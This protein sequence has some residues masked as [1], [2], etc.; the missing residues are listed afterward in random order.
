[1][2]TWPQMLDEVLRPFA[3]KSIAK[4]LNSL[5]NITKLERLDLLH[6]EL[7]CKTFQ[8]NHF[9][10]SLAQFMCYALCSKT[11]EEQVH[12][13]GNCVHELGCILDILP[14]IPEAFHLYGIQPQV[15]SVHNTT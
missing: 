9:T 15:A 13:N 10:H 8:S 2:G 11:L 3:M 6:M 4:N 1:M 5:Q 12:Q 7:M 14:S